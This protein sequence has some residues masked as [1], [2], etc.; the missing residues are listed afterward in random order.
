MKKQTVI[1]AFLISA[2]LLTLPLSLASAI[3]V[4]SVTLPNS[5]WIIK[6]SST[7]PTEPAE[8]DP[9]GAGLIEYQN[10]QNYDFIM[11]YYENAVGSM[12]GSELKADIEHIFARDHEDTAMTSSGTMTIAGVTAGYARGMDTLDNGLQVNVLELAFQKDGEY[13]NVFAYYDANSESE[14]Q[15]MSIL[16]SITVGGTAQTGADNSLFIYI[17]IIVVVVVVV[18]V[19]LLLVLR[20][21]KPAAQP[22]AP[23][24]A[25][26]A[27]PPP[28]PSM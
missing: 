27:P 11:M 13:F 20:K 25:P 2:I 4:P 3:T 16:N 19:V 5:D 26:Q 28:P 10:Q 7:Y 9:Q 1:I 15:A 23:A 12:S 14:S 22:M 21:R 24:Y 8:H 17:G 6:S 18:V